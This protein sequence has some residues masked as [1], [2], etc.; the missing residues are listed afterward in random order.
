MNQFKVSVF[1]NFADKCFG[2]NGWVGFVINK[3]L[4]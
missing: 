1:M 2:M 4:D 3:V